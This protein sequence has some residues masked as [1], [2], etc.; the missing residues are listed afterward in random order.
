MELKV[1]WLGLNRH[2]YDVFQFTDF[3]SGRTEVLSVDLPS[4]RKHGQDF[5]ASWLLRQYE[6]W[7]GSQ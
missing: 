5:C 2:L 7:K 6:K 4:A 1:K 3:D